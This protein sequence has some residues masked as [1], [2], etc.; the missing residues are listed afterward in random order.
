MT[1]RQYATTEC[2]H[3]EVRLEPPP[4]T[5]TACPVCR[6]VIYV[7]TGPDGF[8]YLLQVADLQVIEDAWAEYYA[9]L[10]STDPTEL[11]GSPLRG[12]VAVAS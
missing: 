12:A 1:E 9:S 4:W 8:T 3:C 10:D 5:K 6:R 7:A 11:Y 2:P